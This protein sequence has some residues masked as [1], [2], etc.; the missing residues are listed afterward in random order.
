MTNKKKIITNSILLLSILIFIIIMIVSFGDIKSISDTVFTADYRYIL[1]MV[2]LII[3]YLIIWPISLVLLI[4]GGN[5]QIGRR[6]SYLISSSEFFFN[7][8]TPFSSGGQPFQV[9]AMKQKNV[10]ISESTSILMMNFLI[11]QILINVFSAIAI[12]LYFNSIT[13]DNP[14]IIGISIF[15]FTMNFLMLLLLLA[16]ALSKKV[17]QW[18]HNFLAWLTKFKIFHW[19]ENKIDSFDEYA[20]EVHGAFLEIG[21]KWKTVL[22]STI[23]KIIALGIYYAIPFFGLLAL[24]IE[25][26][27]EYLFYVMSMTCFAMTM[28]VWIP[29]PGASGGA[30]FA[31]AAIFATLALNNDMALS[32]MLIWRFFSYYL[33]MIYGFICYLLFERSRKKDENRNIHGHVL[34]TD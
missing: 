1:V 14:A 2:A 32:L 8:I 11:Y 34:S 21:A 10:K 24:H 19:L 7:G 25:I 27:Y 9:Y 18:I 26:S 28:V 17:T 5:K 33:I 13:R 12:S 23:L 22:V 29:T 31:F 4:R 6:D 16:L 30:E 15:G 20:D 3:V